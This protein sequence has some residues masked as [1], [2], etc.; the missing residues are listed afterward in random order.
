MVTLC[1]HNNLFTWYINSC[2]DNPQSSFILIHRGL[3]FIWMF[4]FDMY[5]SAGKVSPGVFQNLWFVCIFG[6][7]L[8]LPS[9]WSDSVLSS[10][11]ESQSYFCCRQEEYLQSMYISGSLIIDSP[12]EN[13]LTLTWLLDVF[14]FCVFVLDFS[15]N[16]LIYKNVLLV[17]W[18]T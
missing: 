2:S 8:L 14:W 10:H 15:M 4:I 18:V 5:C 11:V 13:T 6:C 3:V 7:L 17:F 12:L 16:T 1:R 9:G